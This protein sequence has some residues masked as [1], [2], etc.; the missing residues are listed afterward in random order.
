MKIKVTGDGTVTGTRVVDESGSDISD[1]VTAVRFEHAAGKL[2]RVEVDLQFVE[3][4]F[5][6]DGA[7]YFKGRQIE[8]IVYADGGE[9][10]F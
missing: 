3:V 9:E 6:G 1:A 2:P 10:L 5:P 8:R 7:F 4:G